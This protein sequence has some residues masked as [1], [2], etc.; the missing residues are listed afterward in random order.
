MSFNLVYKEVIRKPNPLVKSNYL[1]GGTGKVVSLQDRVDTLQKSYEWKKNV[2]NWNHINKTID[3]TRLPKVSMEKLGDLWIDEDIQ[4]ELD[5]GHCAKKIGSFNL[6]D[7]A[8]L[9]PARCIKT[10]DGRF[11]SIDSQHTCATIAAL[12]D[13][14]FMTGLS[15]WREFRFPFHYIET[16]NRAFARKAFG[17]LN[18]KGVKRQSQFQQL[19]TSLYV[20]RIDKDYSDPDDVADEKKVAAAEK[21]NCFPVEKGSKLANYAGTFTNIATFKTMNEKEIDL[22]CSWHDRYFHYE[23]IH[24]S[25]FFIFR[26]IYRSFDALNIPIT[27]KLKEDLAAL[28]QEVFGNLFQYQESVTEAYRKWCKREF[29]RELEWDDGAYVSALLQLYVKFGGEE[30]IS[31]NLVKKFEGISDFFDRDLIDLHN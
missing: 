4:R 14:G 27:D 21:Y 22:A 20:I 31:K 25:L 6:F 18:G 26:E 12:I 3:T 19:R 29:D 23:P 17:K 9:S 16:D 11:I 7:P 2:R 10:S 15:D 30:R 1:K 28:I 24:V 13:S 8:L 5:E